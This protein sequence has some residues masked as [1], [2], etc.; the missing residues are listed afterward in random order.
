MKCPFKMAN[1]EI[2]SC[3][4]EGNECAL[5]LKVKNEDIYGSGSRKI[6]S[7]CALAFTAG[8][9]LKGCEVAINTFSD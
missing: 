6:V 8:G 3:E 2:A 9:L 5:W 4:C 7:G 1:A